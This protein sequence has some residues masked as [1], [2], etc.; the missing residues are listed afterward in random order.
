M[1]GIAE[2]QGKKTLELRQ[3]EIVYI[4]EIT[5]GVSPRSGRAWKMRNVNIKFSVGMNAEGKEETMLVSARCFDELCDRI[6]MVATGTRICAFVRLDVNARFRIPQT[7]CTL[8][9][10]TFNN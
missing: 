8:V 7:E 5:S 1:I 3:A 10:F 6:G 9:D 4:G 2:R